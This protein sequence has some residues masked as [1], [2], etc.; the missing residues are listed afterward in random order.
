MSVNIITEQRR[1]YKRRYYSQH[2]GLRVEEEKRR[3][4]KRK[5]EVPFIG[6]DGEGSGTDEHG[7]QLYMLFRMGEAELYTGKPLGTYEILDFICRQ[8]SY[9]IYV[10]FAFAYDVTMILRDLPEERQRR[11]LQPKAFEPGKSRYT[12]WRD[13]D[14]DYLPKQFFKVRKVRVQ[15]D[16]QGVE[17]RYPIPGTGRT[18]FETFG[19]FQKSF[20][21]VLEEFDVGTADERAFIA[22]NKGGRGKDD[23]SVD[24]SVRHYCARECELLGNLMAKLR[25]YCIAGEIVPRTWNGAGKLANALHSAHKTP[26]SKY[27]TTVPQEALDFASLAYYGGRFEIT[28][29]GKI[30]QKIYEYDIRSA[31]P[32]AMQYLPCL[33]HGTWEHKRKVSVQDELAVCKVRFWYDTDKPFP[34]AGFPVRSKNGHLFWPLVG[35]G[36]YWTPE[37]NAARNL[38]HNVSLGEGWVYQKNC[39]CKPFGWVEPLYEYR[40]SIGSSG[41]GYPIKLGINSLY[42]KLAQRKGNGVYNNM[43]WA[44]LITA[45]TRAWL[46]EGIAQAPDAIVMLATDA[47]YSLEPLELPCGPWLGQWEITEHKGLFIVQPGLY[48]DAERAKR[49]SRGLP[50]K[51]FEAPGLIE[52][53]ERTWSDFQAAENSGLEVDLPKVEVPVP[54]FIGMKLALARGKPLTAGCWVNASRN[55]S[56]DYSNKRRSHTWEGEHIHT[57]PKFGYPGLVSLPHKDTP[58]ELWEGQRLELEEQP[59]FVDLSAPFMQ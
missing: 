16:E 59:D 48:W 52:H 13:F 58:N 2:P 6:C 24:D 41:P 15:T 1:E 14:I 30:A 28:R 37:I 11:L 50:G 19:F 55:I 25:E 12:W 3:T 56:F 34:L 8:P 27:L 10:G 7:R 44:G 45:Y 20:L 4:F 9:G 23:W 22:E 42:G 33:L 21:K 43:I 32:A 40:R 35:S 29:T 31:Y 47:L 17:R 46:M 5:H 49:K 18:I 38:G 53:F 57:T 51:F 39:D 26:R 54:G 36:W